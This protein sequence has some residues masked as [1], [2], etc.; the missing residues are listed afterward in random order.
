[1]STNNTTE[2]TTEIRNENTAENAK[3]N[4]SN[5][6]P[7]SKI[8]LASGVGTLI[9]LVL[10]GIFKIFS[11]IGIIGAIG[12]SQDNTVV[13]KNSFLKLDLTKAVNERTP[14]ELAAFLEKGS[15][16]GFNDMVRSIIA[17]AED[18]RID[19]LYLYMGSMFPMSWGMSEELRQA[20]LHFSESGKP[21]LAYA[22]VYSQQG[23]FVASVADSI[24]LNP[25]GMLE[26][27]GIGAES[28][29]F[30]DL[31][32]K[33]GIKMTLVRPK[34]NSFK[35]AGEM[36]TMNHMSDANRQQIRE[37]INS[38]WEY[39][40]EKIGESRDI[41]TEQLNSLA[42]NL[43]AF[44]PEDAVKA[45]LVDR[46]C[47]EADIKASMVNSYKSKNIITVEEY[48]K[49][50]ESDT[51]AKDKIAII[52]AEGEVMNGSGTGVNVYSDKI[53]K[54]LNDAAADESIKA[55]VL[56]VNSPGGMVTASEIM[57]NAVIRAKQKKPV[58]VSMGDVA[59][60]AGYEISC[61]A[62]YIVAEPTTITG[63]IGVFGTIPEVGN[64]LKKYLG[65]TTDTVNTNANSTGL[66]ILRPMSPKSLEL[67]QR[68][69]EEFYTI[70]VSRVAK[71][72]GLT[73]DFVD[74]IA[75]GRVWT[76]RD[77]LK[78]GL[79]DALGGL[80]DAITIAADSAGISKYRIVDYPEEDDFLTQLLKRSESSSGTLTSS[81]SDLQA[82]YYKDLLNAYSPKSGDGVWVFADKVN[83]TLDR[84]LNTRGL[85]ARVEF[86]IIS[87]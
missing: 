45:S 70:F 37:Y 11:F 65:V 71:G 20:L 44:L 63:S 48:A 68:N 35:S 84:I 7:F 61:N 66:G 24:Y 13:A 82:S 56:R 5:S 22:D 81:A 50:V 80:D 49:T 58:I 21:I 41:S 86:L 46:L 76:G 83:Q 14:D 64:A 4:K 78:L 38:I 73:Y 6:T 79:V 87:E 52:Y 74:S 15:T 19:G 30:K 85:Q 23:Y 34:S 39:V 47:F 55:I 51:K 17:A 42:D 12:S 43:S 16:V 77:A 9:V 26:F 36:Y 59:A 3:N 27:R 75:R 40:V 8:M 33:L 32:D 54:A 31:L 53:T 10:L 1:M 28:L 2:N 62:N 67:M 69:V 60:S 29:F 25:S 72:R 57:T 18:S